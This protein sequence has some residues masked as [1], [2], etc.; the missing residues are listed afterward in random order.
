M[1]FTD[2]ERPRLRKRLLDKN[3]VERLFNRIR[4]NLIKIEEMDKSINIDE[5]E[6]LEKMI[7]ANR[8]TSINDLSFT[9]EMIEALLLNMS[10]QNERLNR[11]IEIQSLNE[12]QRKNETDKL[13]SE[14]DNTRKDI[15]NLKNDPI[16]RWLDN[17]VKHAS[18]TTDE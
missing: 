16:K 18:E 9:M 6:P 14:I 8:R 10:D 2:E 7:I 3:T 12:I 13:I 1:F 15:D 17:Y 11:L 5:Y 4:S